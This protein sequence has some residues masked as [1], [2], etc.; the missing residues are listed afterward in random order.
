MY[1]GRFE[2]FAPSTLDEA[3]STLDRLGEHGAGRLEA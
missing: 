3:M 2:Y 1:P